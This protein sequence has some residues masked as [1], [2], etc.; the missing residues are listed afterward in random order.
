ML[1]PIFEATL[2]II[3]L[4]IIVVTLYLIFNLLITAVDVKNTMDRI[5]RI[6][7]RRKKRNN[8]DGK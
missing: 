4:V 8:Q 3:W 1:N 7:D 2:Y 6:E 5:E